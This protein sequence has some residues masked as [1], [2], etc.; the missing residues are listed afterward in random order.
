LRRPELSLGEVAY[1]VGY[2]DLTAFH[3]AFKRWLGQS[4]SEYRSRARTE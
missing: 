1:R 3:K 4:P 2:E